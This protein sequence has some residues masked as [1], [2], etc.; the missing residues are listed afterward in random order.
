MAQLQVP[1]T[2]AAVSLT[3]ADT[4]VV[5]ADDVKVRGLTVTSTGAA[6]VKIT[7]V[8]GWKHVSTSAAITVA[9]GS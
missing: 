6:T 1:G 5:P 9:L 2:G 4:A 7:E 3:A 8:G